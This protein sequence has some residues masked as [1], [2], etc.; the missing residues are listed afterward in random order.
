MQYRS[1]SERKLKE[2]AE[3]VAKQQKGEPETLSQLEDERRKNE[4]LLFRFEEVTA[5]KADLEVSTVVSRFSV[6]MHN[7]RTEFRQRISC[8]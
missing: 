1:D 3:T 6:A 2:A 7:L 8:T 4:D 5:A